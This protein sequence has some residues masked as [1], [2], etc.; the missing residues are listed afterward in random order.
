[1]PHLVM[2]YTPQLDAQTDI[3]GFCRKLANTMLSVKDE[4]GV[5]SY[6]FKAPGDRTIKVKAGETIRF[7]LKNSGNMTHEMVLGSMDDLRDHAEMMRSM[8]DMKH[9]AANMARLKPGQR[10]GI[11]WHFD[12]AGTVNFA[13]LVPGHM[14][15]GM[16]GQIVVDK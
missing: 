12:E 11:V 4:N 8:P 2:L 1:M 7:F 3:S 16:V 5:K 9:D 15:G 14:E 13:C 6:T 10:G